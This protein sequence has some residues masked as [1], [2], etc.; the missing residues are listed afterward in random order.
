M[1]EDKVADTQRS[2]PGEDLISEGC[3]FLAGH[4]DQGH[5]RLL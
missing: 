3:G 2:E 4:G 1:L 5:G